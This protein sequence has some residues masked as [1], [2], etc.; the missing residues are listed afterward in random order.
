MTTGSKQ[1]NEILAQRQQL[2]PI[3]PNSP[4]RQNAPRHNWT[5]QQEEILRRDFLGTRE[6]KERIARELGLTPDQV[7]SKV[8]KLGLTTLN[9]RRPWTHPEDDRLRELTGRLSLNQIARAMNRTQH[10]IRVRSARLSISRLD[11]DAWYTLQETSEILGKHKSWVKKRMESGVL[12]ASH[13][14]QQGNSKWHIES[15]DLREFIRLYCHELNGRNVD[16]VQ[17]V[18]ILTGV[19]DL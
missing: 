14:N 5:D 8:N 15:K 4:R 9:D 10:S 12:R 16:L 1:P 17:I 6:S 11:R 13:H 18:N 2:P 19:P 3:R 7:Q